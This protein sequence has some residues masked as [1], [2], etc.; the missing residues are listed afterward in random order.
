VYNAKV[1]VPYFSGA[2]FM[3]RF[4]VLATVLFAALGGADTARAGSIRLTCSKIESSTAA[5]AI[6]I[7]VSYTGQAKQQQIKSMLVVWTL[8]DGSAVDRISQ[9]PRNLKFDTSI[10]W[11]WSGEEPGTTHTMNGYLSWITTDAQTGQPVKGSW[12]YT[13]EFW[14]TSTRAG[15]EITFR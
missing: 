6:D 12:K 4:V 13:E 7:W 3:Q 5:N 2:A 9:Y 15:R 1:L 8:P 14:P 11:R 10:G